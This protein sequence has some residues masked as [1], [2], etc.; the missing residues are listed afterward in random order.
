MKYA[1][2]QILPSPLN[3]FIT[4]HKKNYDFLFQLKEINLNVYYIFSKN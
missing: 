2:F 4:T 3:T 1:L